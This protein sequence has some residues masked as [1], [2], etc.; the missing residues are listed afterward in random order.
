M[1][2]LYKNTSNTKLKPR[3]KTGIAGQNKIL[4][5]IKYVFLILFAT[6][7][8]IPIFLTVIGGFKSLGQLRQSFLALPNPIEWQNYVDVLSPFR[9]TFFLNLFNSLFIMVFTVTLE[10]L[11]SCMAGYA[12]S[13]LK[14]KGRELIY[15]YFLLGLL[16]PLA[17]AIL[18]LYI[19]I[20]NMGLLN[21]YFGVILPQVAFGMPWNIMLTR[22]FFMQIPKE[23][24]ESAII[25][26]CSS[27]RFF[28]QFMLPL[29][30]PILATIAVLTMVASWNNFFL[31][32]LIL[33][34]DKLFTLPM[35][36]MQFQGQYMYNY[37]LVLTFITLAIIPVIVVYLLTQKYII[38]GLTGG[39]IKG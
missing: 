2:P 29:S 8:L 13:R 38:A 18:P 5:F 7:T 11:V 32:L 39:S 12:L 23:I 16:F 35:G 34:N 30:T 19:E 4:V 17:V 10:L 14:F 37:N 20:K 36:V 6:L 15:N 1:K 31:P 27:L 26:G 21:N 24:E 22:S 33:N 25:D 28:L 3:K 9:S